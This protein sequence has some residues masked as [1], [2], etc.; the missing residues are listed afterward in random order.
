MLDRILTFLT[1]K[2]SISSASIIETLK[3]SRMQWLRFATFVRLGK[4]PTN[5]TFTLFL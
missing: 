2:R 4:V 1:P 5:H 3:N